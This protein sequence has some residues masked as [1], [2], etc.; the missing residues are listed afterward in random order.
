MHWQT[1][2]ICVTCF[3]VCFIEVV[4]NGTHISNACLYKED[5]LKDLKPLPKQCGR[6]FHSLDTHTTAPSKAS[7]FIHS[8]CQEKALRS[9]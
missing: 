4:W 1:K 6:A 3:D 5:S 8:L 7:S 9:I 2:Q